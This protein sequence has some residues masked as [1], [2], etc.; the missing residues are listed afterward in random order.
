MS[1]FYKK[2]CI[3]ILGLVILLNIFVYKNN[4]VE[5]VENRK[6]GMDTDNKEAML[7]A[8]KNEN[9]LKILTEKITE[10][11]NKKME[12]LKTTCKKCAKASENV[13]TH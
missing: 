2:L 4:I 11:F 8:Q 5:G 13:P 7:L 3:G 1:K 6:Q 9:S 12:D 10:L